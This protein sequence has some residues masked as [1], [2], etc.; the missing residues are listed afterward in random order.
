MAGTTG[1]SV[2]PVETES[3]SGRKELFL[4]FLAGY[5][6]SKVTDGQRGRCVTEDEG[7]IRWQVYISV[8]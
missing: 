1:S 6:H 7:E 8:L 4:G 5:S 2:G 3:E